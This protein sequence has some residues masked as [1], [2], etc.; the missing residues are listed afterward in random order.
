MA[1]R[2]SVYQRKSDGRWVGKLPM[3]DDPLTGEKQSPKYVYSA[4]CPIPK[5]KWK[6]DKD[7]N[8]ILPPYR[9]GEQEAERKLEALIAKVDQ[10]D[11]TG[12]DKYTLETWLV[13]YLE[14]YC[15]EIEDTTRD[16]YENYIFNHIVPFMGKLP[17]HEIR[18][19]HIQNFYNHEREVPRYR[20][21]IK[22]GKTVPIL[23]NGVPT[24]LIKNGKPVIG[25]S[26]KTLQ[27]IHRILSRAFSKAKG[28]RLIP[29]NPCDGVDA[30]SPVSF[31]PNVYTAEDYR[32]LLS[33][34][35]GHKIEKA[36]L[37]VGMCGLRRAEF[38]GLDWQKSFDL[39]SGIIRVIDTVVA[40]KKGNKEK[41]PKNET[42]LR[43]FSIPSV[44]LPRLKELQ[45]VG[46]V[47]TRNDGDDYDPRSISN[48]F[49]KFLVDNDLKQIRLH[50]LRHF[51]ATM[52]LQSKISDKEAA[53]RLGHSDPSITR[54]LYQHVLKEMDKEN[55]DKLNS[56][57]GDSITK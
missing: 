9:K 12:I 24:P 11:K 56:V 51:N 37:I 50:D 35:K 5:S 4:V 48:M 53:Q 15:T 8:L 52:M 21:R 27:Q 47:F 31:K 43:E 6:K 7:G 2:G 46:R 45:G 25:Y 39:K 20:T 1:S 19:M 42:S 57:I 10:G 44:I 17:L 41:L 40:T 32:L 3:P 14:I 33:K 38:A 30:P 22:D 29:V 34:A 23:K 28:D 36:I 26:E 49:K 13:K 18:P 54:K 16:G 55:A